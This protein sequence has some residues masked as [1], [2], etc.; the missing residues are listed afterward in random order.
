M[1]EIMGF[2]IPKFDCSNCDANDVKSL[3][4]SG[5]T[6]PRYLSSSGHLRDIRRY[7]PQKTCDNGSCSAPFSL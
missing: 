3:F 1:Y 7:E 4:L 2:N 6:F 5:H